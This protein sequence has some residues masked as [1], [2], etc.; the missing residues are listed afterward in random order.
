MN[1]T[2]LVLCDAWKVPGKAGGRSGEKSEVSTK[3]KSDHCKAGLIEVRM[4]KVKKPRGQITQNWS[5]SGKV[6]TW[7][8]KNGKGQELSSVKV[9]QYQV[10]NTNFM[11]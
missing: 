9:P 10:R 1:W 2:P 4:I 8:G 6:S 7:N 3:L 5:I 11:N